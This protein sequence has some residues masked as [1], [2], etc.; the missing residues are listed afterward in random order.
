M[1]TDTGWLSS[2]NQKGLMEEVKFKLLTE[3]KVE[4]SSMKR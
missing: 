2:K 1:F 4:V 3:K